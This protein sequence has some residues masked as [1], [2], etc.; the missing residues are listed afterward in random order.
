MRQGREGAIFAVRVLPRASRTAITGVM[1]EGADAVL[2]IALATPPVDGR[3]NEELVALL[4]GV[5]GGPRS[6]VAVIAGL[7]SRNKRIRVRGRSADEVRDALQRALD[8]E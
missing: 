6:D 2:K 4:A 5:L 8:G 7:K 3:A 1:G